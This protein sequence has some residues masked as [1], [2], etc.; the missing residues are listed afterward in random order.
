MKKSIKIVI[1]H[2]WIQDPIAE[3]TNRIIIIIIC[4][5]FACCILQVPCSANKDI[6]VFKHNIHL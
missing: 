6:H 4:L 3:E 5:F 1:T 2:V